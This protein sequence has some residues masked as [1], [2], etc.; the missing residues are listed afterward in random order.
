M[1]DE[2]VEVFK[3]AID[4]T[5]SRFV[6]IERKHLAHVLSLLDEAQ[7]PT[8]KVKPADGDSKR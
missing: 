5:N 4:K 2:I 8:L 6:T 3:Q 1:P 7:K